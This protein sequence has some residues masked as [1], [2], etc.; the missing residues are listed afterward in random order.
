MGIL[1]QTIEEIGGQLTGETE[2]RDY[3]FN[4]SRA[5]QEGKF[6]GLPLDEDYEADKTETR[7]DNWLKGLRNT[8]EGG[9]K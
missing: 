9:Q 7:I 3:I 1:G 2:T 5:L 6:I 8:M 4:D